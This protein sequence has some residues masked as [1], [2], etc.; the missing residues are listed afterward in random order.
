MAL[1]ISFLIIAGLIYSPLCNLK[2]ALSSC[3]ASA[4]TKPEKANEQS[5]HCHRHSESKEQ[6]SSQ[7]QTPSTPAR[8]NDSSDCPAHL[9]AAAL[10]PHAVSPT[11]QLHTLAQ[12]LAV[13]LP[14]AFNFYFDQRG[15]IR[16][17]GT[18]FRS[19]PARAAVVALRI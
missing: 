6:Y 18:A 12:P 15:A 14:A 4:A 19:P 9:D 17:E 1:A 5:S 10:M 13:A 8:H 11:A 2:C 3:A 16:N 7:R